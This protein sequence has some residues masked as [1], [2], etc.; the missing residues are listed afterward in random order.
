MA[1]STNLKHPE[2]MTSTALRKYIS[3]VAQIIHLEKGELEWLANHLGHDLEVH[4]SFYR[5]HKST[6]ELSKVS[7]LLLT[8]D[9]GSTAK[10]S[11]KSLAKV[12]MMQPDDPNDAHDRDDGDDYEHNLEPNNSDCAETDDPDDTCDISESSDLADSDANDAGGS[13]AIPQLKD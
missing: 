12:H 5:I 3:T 2:L 4:K 6:V 10:F 11:G 8:V 9:S 1:K 7:C 13:L